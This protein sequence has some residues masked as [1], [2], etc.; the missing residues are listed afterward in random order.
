MSINNEEDELFEE[1]E[2]VDVSELIE[3]GEEEGEENTVPGVPPGYRVIRE[4]KDVYTLKDPQGNTKF[5]CKYCGQLLDRPFDIPR[6]KRVCPKIPR[7]AVEAREA[8]SVKKKLGIP[9]KV[10]IG[11]E[12][13]RPI[14]DKALTPEEEA[15]YERKAK[16]YQML[17]AA[18]GIKDEKRVKWVC[19]VFENTESLRNSPETLYFY[20]KT[21]FPKLRD[22]DAEYIVRSVF[23]DDTGRSAMNMPFFGDFGERREG[24]HIPR[25]E[26]MHRGRDVIGI[27]PP[28]ENENLTRWAIAQLVELLKDRDRGATSNTVVTQEDI[29]RAREMGR[30]EAELEFYKHKVEDLE[31]RVRDI[32]TGKVKLTQTGRSEWD[33]AGDFLDRAFGVGDRAVAE[34]AKITRLITAIVL[35]KRTG[36]TSDEIYSI[37][38]SEA[39]EYVGEE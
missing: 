2:D 12:T 6:H 21:Q 15:T 34:F 35:G 26:D 24:V 7:E 29:E 5:M 1:V 20:L 23:E 39:P 18:P 14:V 22:K 19:D 25:F 28:S 38:K 3:K 13:E 32:L 33:V 16:L 17:V 27:R 31:Q 36:M 9:E 10:D 8:E 30:K 4:K 11:H 37:V